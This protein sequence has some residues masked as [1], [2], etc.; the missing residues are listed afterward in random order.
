M[1]LS[2]SDARSPAVPGNGPWCLEHRRDRR[3]PTGVTRKE[4]QSQE[5][6]RGS[7]RRLAAQGERGRRR[8]E[9]HG[10]QP[11]EGTRG[12][13]DGGRELVKCDLCSLDLAT[14]RPW[15]LPAESGRGRRQSASL[16]PLSRR[17]LSARGRPVA[18]TRRHRSQRVPDHVSE[19]RSAG[20]SSTGPQFPQWDGRR[21]V[22]SLPS[23]GRATR[24]S[25]WHTAS[26]GN[27]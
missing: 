2:G 7:R 27:A 21:Y 12:S 11:E 8:E 18:Q 13:V 3:G 9:G 25:P 20:P 15:R 19:D 5:G 23:P 22:G 6:Q 17:W 26:P 10:S 1:E 16:G 24:G 4:P 14:G